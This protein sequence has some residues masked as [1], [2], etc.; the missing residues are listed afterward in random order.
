MALSGSAA[1][2]N[3]AASFWEFFQEQKSLIND[4]AGRQDAWTQLRALDTK[5]REALI[6]LPPYDQKHLTAELESLRKSLQKGNPSSLRNT[7]FRF[8]SATITRP[9]IEARQNT[10]T[11]NLKTTQQGSTSDPRLM[12]VSGNAKP[13]FMF[14]DIERQWVVADN[15]ASVS[16]PTDCE[17]RDISNC[18]VDL[19]PIGGVLRALNCHRVCN[20]IIICTPFSGAATIR[21]A[22]KCLVILAVRQLR[23]ES[24]KNVGVYTHCSSHP[25]IER[26]SGMYFA[27]YPS[28]IF[29]NSETFPIISQTP[30][31]FDQV[32]DFNWLK[33]THSPNWSLVDTASNDPV[34]QQLW[35]I[36][37]SNSKSLDAALACL[38]Q[39]F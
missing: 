23:F 37:N 10:S 16:E 2:A 30:N 9:D 17:L 11:E 39:S 20:S 14:T 33:R 6:Y 7:G 26:S 4:A 21:H 25:V 29:Q 19:R 1:N 34:T 15:T 18:V 27:P 5:L 8:K 24:S 28:D 13:S 35:S 36:L 22:H 12:Y 3:A 32:D 31:M 38:E